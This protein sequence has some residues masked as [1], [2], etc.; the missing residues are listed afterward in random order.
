MELAR[1]WSMH[2]E[3]RFGQLMFNIEAWTYTKH[4]KDSFYIE[5][6]EFMKIIRDK[7]E[8]GA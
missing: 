8:V 7:L 6:D 2:P 4:Q 5:D 1:L 3:M